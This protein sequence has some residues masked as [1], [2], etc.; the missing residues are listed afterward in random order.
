MGC[1]RHPFRIPLGLFADLDHRVHEGIELGLAFGLGGLDEEALG[2]QQREVGRRRVEAVVEQPLGEV[3][4]GDA[5]GLGLVPEGDD[6]LV[7]GGPLRIRQ[8]EPGGGQPHHHVVGVQGGVLADPAHA[9][10]AEHS[11]IRQGAQQDAGI[12]HEGR[13]ATDGL[14]CIL[15]FHPPVAGFVH[16]HVWRRQIR[17]EAFVHA[18]RTRAGSAAAV[19]C[20]EGLVQVQVQDVE[21]H[22]RGADV[23]E[24]GVQVRAV[25]VE[26]SPGAVHEVRDL[27]D[28]ALEQAAGGGIGEHDAGG[29]LTQGRLEGIH[30]DVAVGQDTDFAHAV[31]AHD[32]RRGIGAVSG[33]RDEDLVASVVAAGVVPGAD[34][35]DPGELPLGTRHRRQRHRRHAGDGLQDLLQLVEAG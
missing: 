21:A 17:Q 5:E 32:G 7:A 29:M 19:G 8:F 1:G 12:A 15:A 34:H 3:H 18:H 31:A 4:G 28:A 16:G 26:E 20:G 25:V 33:G 14:R 23:A 30:V 27:A 24:D 6:E 10:A 13:Q 11:R 2:D 22:V 35:G 9:V